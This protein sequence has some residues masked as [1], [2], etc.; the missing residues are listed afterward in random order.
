MRVYVIVRVVQRQHD[1]PKKRNEK[2]DRSTEKRD[3][4]RMSNRIQWACG[5]AGISGLRH[6]N[7]HGRMET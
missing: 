5:C 6:I 4:E 1:E 3:R 2:A 7:H